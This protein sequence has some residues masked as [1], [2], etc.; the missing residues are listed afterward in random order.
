LRLQPLEILM[1]ATTIKSA[2]VA[3]IKNKGVETD[4][5]LYDVVDKQSGESVYFTRRELK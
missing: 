1:R 4:L 2:I 3:V 5:E